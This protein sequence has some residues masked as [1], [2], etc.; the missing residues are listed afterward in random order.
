MQAKESKEMTAMFGELVGTLKSKSAAA[1]VTATAPCQSHKAPSTSF[2]SKD[3][4]YCG[5]GGGVLI[6]HTKNL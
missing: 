6:K 5:I 4:I 2:Q 3:M 1:P